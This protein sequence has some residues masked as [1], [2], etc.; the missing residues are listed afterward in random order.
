M[1]IKEILQKIEKCYKYREYKTAIFLSTYISHYEKRFSLLT[2]ILLYLNDEF[3]RALEFLAKINTPT[4]FYYKAL[5]FKKI[6]KYSYAINSL[7]ILNKNTNEKECQKDSFCSDFV[8]R[9]IINPSDVEFFNSLMCELYIM[10]GKVSDAIEYGKTAINKEPLLTA[11]EILCNNNVFV[12]NPYLKTDLIYTFYCDVFSESE[13][14]INYQKMFPGFGSFYLAKKAAKY[15]KSEQFDE[16]A[17]L[18]L[19]LRKNDF[20]FIE[21]QE[22]YSSYLWKTKNPNLLGLLGKELIETHPYDYRTW[23]VI[24]NYYSLKN[25]HKKCFK[26]LEKSIELKE[27]AVAYNLLGFECNCRSQYAKAQTYFYSS[28]RMCIN[29]SKANFGMGIALDQSFKEHE[30][31]NYLRKGLDLNPKDSSMQTYILRFYVKQKSYEKALVAFKMFI[32]QDLP[33][34]ELVE[35]IKKNMGS[36]STTEE[37]MI[38]EFSEIVF[39]NG[40]KEA[41]RYLLDCVQ[42]RTSSFYLKLN[43]FESS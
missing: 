13:P 9:F 20:T 8:D 33:L 23:V 27:N 34:L 3:A 19:Q 2:G 25:S 37:L 21:E 17:N 14:Q 1:E 6:K 22:N 18:F 40:M 5:C 35:Y 16:G 32:K 12:N 11:T 38:L 36:F 41:A 24:A 4:S 10:E 30:A 39:A 7:N 26:C 15:I 29:N 28:L 31:E 42:T 43:T